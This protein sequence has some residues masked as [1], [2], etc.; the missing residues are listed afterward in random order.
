MP[1]CHTVVHFEVKISRFEPC[2]RTIVLTVVARLQSKG[3][4]FNG[5]LQCVTQN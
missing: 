3:S 2:F 5:D 1:W 4:F